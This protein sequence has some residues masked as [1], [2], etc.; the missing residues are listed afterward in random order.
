MRLAAVTTR[1]A[2]IAALL[3]GA[4]ACLG[5]LRARNVPT[6]RAALTL[7]IGAHIGFGFVLFPLTFAHAWFSM[8]AAGMNASSIAGLWIATV[9]LLLLLWQAL[10]GISLLRSR[11][12]VG[13]RR[14]HLAIAV[15]VIILAAVH[16]FLN[17]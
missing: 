4:Q 5:L 15:V 13:S 3:L 14:L 8:K 1:T 12:A 10:V 9:A 11:H 7:A 17:R 6:S 2:W 16:G